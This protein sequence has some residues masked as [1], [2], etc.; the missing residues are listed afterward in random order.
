MAERPF[1]D[2]SEG[3]KQL[4]CIL[5]VL[6]MQPGLIVFDEPFSSLDGLATRQI[7]SLIRGWS[8]S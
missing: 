8:R 3:Q 2:L 7:M 1:L 4:I 6:V 5:A